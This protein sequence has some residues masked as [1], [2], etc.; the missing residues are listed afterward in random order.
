MT[1]ITVQMAFPLESNQFSLVPVVS[2]EH[3]RFGLRAV[4]R[5]VSHGRQLRC[6][7]LGRHRRA[8]CVTRIVAWRRRSAQ[9]GN[10][11]VGLGGSI[12]A[13][14]ICAMRVFSPGADRPVWRGT[15]T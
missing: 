1:V 7:F 15:L 12:V 6:R 11:G 14:G 8:A 13:M 10:R 9:A 2:N 3:V 4:I 5:R